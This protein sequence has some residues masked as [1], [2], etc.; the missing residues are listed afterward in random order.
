MIQ[1]RVAEWLGVTRA[2]VSEM[3]RHMVDDGLVVVDDE[4]ELT[5][6]GRHLAEVVVRRHRLA[7]RFLTEVLEMPWV[8]VHAEAEVWEHAISDDV[9]EAMWAKLDDPKTCPHGNPIP[10]AGYR[11]PPVRPLAGLDAGDTATLERISEEL[12]L[13][14]D[15][16]DFL[17]EGRFHPGADLAVVTKTPDGTLTVA[18]GGETDPVHVGVGN[19]IAERLFVT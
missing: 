13:D 17:D 10:G 7:E 3:I 6:S 4:L 2:S 1:A 11:P 15:I 18:V 14:G 19:F 8:K 9:E 16:M 12:E 5:D